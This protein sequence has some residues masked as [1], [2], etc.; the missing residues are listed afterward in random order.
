M[1]LIDTMRLA[2]GEQKRESESHDS[3]V[4]LSKEGLPAFMT[5][6]GPRTVSLELQ[7]KI[8]GGPLLRC[9]YCHD[10]DRNLLLRVFYQG[11]RV[12]SIEVILPEEIEEPYVP[13]HVAG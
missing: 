11:L 3:D 10:E 13:E 6:I 1:G 12:I 5:M 2:L 7:D 9:Q 8:I 4:D